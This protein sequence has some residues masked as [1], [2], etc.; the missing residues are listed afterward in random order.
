M[1]RYQW[2]SRGMEA[3]DKGEYVKLEEA[4]KPCAN[5]EGRGAY[6]AN[7][8]MRTCKSCRPQNSKVGPT[9]HPYKRGADP[10]CPY[11][12]GAGICSAVTLDR[13]P[14]DWPCGCTAGRG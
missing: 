5:C 1:K 2:T 4:R 9:E 13:T 6:M 14:I 7:G 10:D 3:C 11:C 12:K 8:V